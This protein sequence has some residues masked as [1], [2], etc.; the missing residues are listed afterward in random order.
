[1]MESFG[2]IEQSVEGEQAGVTGTD[3][4]KKD[5]AIDFLLQTR[6]MRRIVERG[7]RTAGRGIALKLIPETLKNALPRFKSGDISR[8]SGP[9]IG[10]IPGALEKQFQL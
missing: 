2:E 7:R 8:Q 4:P 6:E 5:A 10:E 1:M 3:T 9:A